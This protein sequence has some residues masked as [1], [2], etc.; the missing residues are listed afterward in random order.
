M[1]GGT[2][3]GVDGLRFIAAFVVGGGADDAAGIGVEGTVTPGL[4]GA[5][6]ACL[7]ISMM[8]S[9]WGGIELTRATACSVLIVMGIE[10]CL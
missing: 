3:A 9:R 1:E 5:E 2:T 8:L 6:A 7:A 10:P 4:G